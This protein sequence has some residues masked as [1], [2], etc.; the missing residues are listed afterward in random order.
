MGGSRCQLSA[1]S[2]QLRGLNLDFGR[3]H[4]A[5]VGPSGDLK[6]LP[7]PVSLARIE[8]FPHHEVDE[9]HYFPAW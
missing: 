8:N 2:S 5:P 3:N 7:V 4:E 9:H 1:V 6:N